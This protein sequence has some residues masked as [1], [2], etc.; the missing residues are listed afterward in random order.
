MARTKSKGLPKVPSTLFPGCVSGLSS[1][2]K[3]GHI[4]VHFMVHFWTLQIQRDLLSVLKW[5][6][7]WAKMC[8][9]FFR[10]RKVPYDL[11]KL[12]ESTSRCPFHFPHLKVDEKQKFFEIFIFSFIS[13]KKTSQM[14]HFWGFTKN[15]VI[16]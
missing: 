9:N 10:A 4:L 14:V 6:T 12:M 7:K 13:V 2:Q 8:P 1:L 15:N 16:Y 5:T 11:Q 3:F